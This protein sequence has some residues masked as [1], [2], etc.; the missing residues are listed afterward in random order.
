MASQMQHLPGWGKYNP[1]DPLQAFLISELGREAPMTLLDGGYFKC[2][3][4][5]TYSLIHNLWDKI[6]KFAPFNAHTQ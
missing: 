4:K 1:G 6:Q 3:G 2:G 5:P